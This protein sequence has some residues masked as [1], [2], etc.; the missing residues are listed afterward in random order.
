MHRYNRLHQRTG[1]LARVCL[2][3]SPANGLTRRDLGQAEAGTARL[4]DSQLED[5]YP[6]GAWPT[7]PPGIIERIAEMLSSA[8]ALR[9]RRLRCGPGDGEPEGLPEVL[10]AEG[11]RLLDRLRHGSLPLHDAGGDRCQRRPFG[12]AGAGEPARVRTEGGTYAG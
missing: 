5:L 9:A 4:I 12:R 2:S 7:T 8:S 3:L 1:Y 10:E 6:T 11:R